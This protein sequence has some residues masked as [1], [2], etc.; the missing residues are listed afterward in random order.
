M[1]PHWQAIRRSHALP[2]SI[3]R[4]TWTNLGGLA[5][6]GQVW[7]H[8][9]TPCQVPMSYLPIVAHTIQPHPRQQMDNVCCS[10]AGVRHAVR[11]CGPSL[12]QPRPQLSGGRLYTELGAQA[13][14]C[15]WHRAAPIAP[16]PFGEFAPT[17]E[18]ATRALCP[19]SLLDTNVVRAPRPKPNGAG[20]FSG[21]L[22][23]SGA[24]VS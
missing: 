8:L 10:H 12:R 5:P 9:V 17:H 20:V 1:W 14:V 7:K 18:E 23:S 22:P 24:P 6:I 3:G 2:R 15:A 11:R 19:W 13:F 21:R 4:P 16:A